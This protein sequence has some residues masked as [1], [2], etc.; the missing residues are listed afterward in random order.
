M[1]P[2]YPV[3]AD[4]ALLVPAINSPNFNLLNPPASP[5][6]SWAILQNGLAYFF[7]LV[8][9][10]GTITGPDY[11]FNQQGLVFY[12][13]TPALGN[14][15]LSIAAASFVDQFGNVINAPGIIIYNQ[16]NTG[17]AALLSGTAP[18]LVLEPPGT[19]TM[20]IAPQLQGFAN[21]AGTGSEQ[22][23]ASLFSGQETSGNANSFVHVFSEAN[24]GSTAAQGILGISGVTILQWSN[25]GVFVSTGNGAMTGR[26]DFTQ[27]D[28][29]V[30]TNANLTG[31]SPA[32]KQWSIPAGDS[33]VGTV[34]LIE[35]A[36]NMVTGTT[37]E[38]FAFKPSLN[39]AAVTTSNGDTI[40]STAMAASTGYTG[41]VRC[42]LVVQSIGNAGTAN[43]FIKG[44][45]SLE[46][47]LQGTVDAW[48]ISSQA[49][50]VAF[51]TL[52]NNTIAID[53]LWGGNPSGSAQSVANHG[54]EFTRKGP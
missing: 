47:N 6:P 43:I 19:I 14:V 49:T 11:I 4:T 10:G 33:Q 51:N 1:T 38:T 45:M 34:Y 30:D 9:S 53:S 5:S 36:F 41:E 42:K 24:D 17:F 13:G 26:P 29:T 54:S 40:G 50:G 3:V 7:G 12:N 25:G 23:A 46:G 22:I 44:G 16:G 39:G 8:L 18:A 28:T 35:S 20:A 31:A 27:T 21:G 52:N 32:T 37:L 48:F 15:V 2:E